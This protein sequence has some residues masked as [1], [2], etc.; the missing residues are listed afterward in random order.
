MH[1][2]KMAQYAMEIIQDA[3]K[4]DPSTHGKKVEKITF[5]Q[6]GPQMVVPDS[7]EFYFSELAKETELSGAAL[8]FTQSNE[9]GFFVSSIELED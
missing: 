6:N 3:I 2:A 5:A 4:S 8:E 7:F 9:T 1:E